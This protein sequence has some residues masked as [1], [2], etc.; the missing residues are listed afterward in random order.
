MEIA[1]AEAELDLARGGAGAPGA[2]HQVFDFGGIFAREQIFEARG[3]RCLV[4]REDLRESAVDA[5]DGAIGA[6]GNDA[7]GDAFE[8]GFGE[9]AAAVE[10]AAGGVEFFDH[11]VER[12]HQIGEFVAGAHFDAMLKVAL[13][14]LVAPRREG[15]RWVR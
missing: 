15:R 12:A 10:F 9:P 14:H 3:A 5:F 2:L 6:D 1:V 8:N 4:R 13:A 7:G 11:A